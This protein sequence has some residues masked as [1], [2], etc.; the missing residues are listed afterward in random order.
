MSNFSRLVL[1]IF[2]IGVGT[3]YA[4]DAPVLPPGVARDKVV[5]AC[6]ECHDA[7]IIVQQRLA[8]PAWLKEVDKMIKWGAVVEAADRESFAEY[9]SA[10]FSPDKP[11]YAADTTER[12]KLKHRSTR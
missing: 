2:M 8:K 9:L 1:S 6:T 10:N 4:A 7:T 3:G 12:T 11:P 5:T